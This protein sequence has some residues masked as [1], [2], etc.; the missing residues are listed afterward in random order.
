M[1]KKLQGQAKRKEKKIT[2]IIKISVNESNYQKYF[3]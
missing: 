2:W 1:I 3:N